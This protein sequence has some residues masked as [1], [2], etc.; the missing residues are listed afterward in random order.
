MAPNREP[1][2]DRR[3]VRLPVV[4][5]A[6]STM[7]FLVVLIGS[8][9]SQDRVS[10]NESTPTSADSPISGPITTRGAE[11]SSIPRDG[12]DRATIPKHT[13]R[14]FGIEWEHVS[15]DPAQLPAPEDWPCRDSRVASGGSDVD[16]I[17]LTDGEIGQLS[18]VVIHQATDGM[19]FRAQQEVFGACT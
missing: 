19:L 15:S 7:A 17:V 8:F 18:L 14:A 9:T 2:S 11:V 13:Q 1:G 16:L 10:T 4:L 5:G 6:V 12:A 3:T